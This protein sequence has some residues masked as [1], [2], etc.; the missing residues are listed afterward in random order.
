MT[1][2]DNMQAIGKRFAAVSDYEVEFDDKGKIQRLHQHYIQDV[3]CS[4]N[5]PGKKLK[6][7]LNFNQL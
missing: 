5:E 3:G 6:F 1:M 4:L 2:E 7:I